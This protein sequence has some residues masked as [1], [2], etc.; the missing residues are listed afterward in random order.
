MLNMDTIVDLPSSTVT[1]LNDVIQSKF[2][3]LEAEGLF[4]NE[5][6]REDI[7]NIL[8]HYCT[9][10]YFPLPDDEENDG[11]HVTMPVDY[12]LSEE[13]EHFV[14]LN[15]SKTIEKQI[16]VAA[17]ELGHIWVSEDLIWTDTLERILPKNPE[18]L[19]IIMNRFAAELLMPSKHFRNTAQD[20]LKKYIQKGR[21]LCIDRA[22]VSRKYLLQTAFFL[23][24][25]RA[26]LVKSTLF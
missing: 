4:F 2:K 6:L 7:F 18:N 8:D 1:A 11:F 21:M 10:V 5:I 24:M 16:F 26:A 13:S 20:C 17:H 15:T 22:L 14:F 3:Q 9:V 25:E 19:D 23:D 12:K